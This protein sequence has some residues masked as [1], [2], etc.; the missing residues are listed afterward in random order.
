MILFGAFRYVVTGMRST[1]EARIGDTL[2]H[3]RTVVEPLPGTYFLSDYFTIF[4]FLLM[5][6]IP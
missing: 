2:F 4:Q 3:A 1:R 6:M 5:A